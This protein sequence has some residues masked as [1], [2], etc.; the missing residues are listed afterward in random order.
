V[1]VGFLVWVGM[2]FFAGSSDRLFV[3]MNFDY[4]SQIYVYRALVFV[5]PFVAGWVAKRWCEE[6]LRYEAHPLRGSGGGRVRRTPGGGF[7]HADE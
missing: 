5:V 7:E 2:I 3:E 1:G 6:L 4:E